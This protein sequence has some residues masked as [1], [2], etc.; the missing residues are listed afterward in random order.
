VTASACQIAEQINAAAIVTF[1]ALGA[2]TLRASRERPSVRRRFF[3]RFPA[4]YLII[5]IIVM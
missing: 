2:T 1:T 3:T 4:R 5:I